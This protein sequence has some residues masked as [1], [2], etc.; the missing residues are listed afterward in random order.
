MGLR[1]AAFEQRRAKIGDARDAG[2]E[3]VPRSGDDGGVERVRQTLQGSVTERDGC[4][5]TD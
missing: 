3:I 1:D 5:G 4:G 2:F